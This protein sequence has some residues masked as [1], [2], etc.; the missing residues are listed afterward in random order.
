M[1]TV[2]AL[3]LIDGKLIA[4]SKNVTRDGVTC[5]SVTRKPVKTTPK[6]AVLGQNHSLNGKYSAFFHQGSIEDTD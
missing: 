5:R 4:K 3:P 2:L 1:G 6:L